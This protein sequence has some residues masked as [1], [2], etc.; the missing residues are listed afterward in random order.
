MPD[1]TEN[2][3]PRG[4]DVPAASDSA[5]AAWSQDET[6]EELRERLDALLNDPL[7]EWLQHMHVGGVVA[8]APFESTLSWRVT[9]PLRAVRLFQIRASQLGVGGAVGHTARYVSRRLGR[10]A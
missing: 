6:V 8:A 3:P 9:K 4:D 10:R 5:T 2:E 7:D 1:V